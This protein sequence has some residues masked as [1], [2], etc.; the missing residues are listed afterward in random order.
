MNTTVTLDQA[1]IPY[2]DDGQGPPIVF[3]HGLLVDGQLWRKVTPH[4]TGSFR[5]IVP[6]LPLGAHA[7]PFEEGAD[8]SPRG[9]AHLL[10]DF[11]EALGL[12]SVT[13]VGSD[14][15]G[16]IAQLLVTQRPERVGSLV[17]TNCDCF[18]NFLPP[19]FRPLQ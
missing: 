12:S 16:A 7:R 5:C 19:M 18:E 15:G 17:L 2:R 13:V 6:D 9:V 8:R 14:T 10:A 4:L 11:F 3:V 1:T